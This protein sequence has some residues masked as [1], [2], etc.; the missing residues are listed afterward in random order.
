M[1]AIPIII[2][3]KLVFSSGRVTSFLPLGLVFRAFGFAF[4]AMVPFLFI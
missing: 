4:T 3:I 2:I 1:T